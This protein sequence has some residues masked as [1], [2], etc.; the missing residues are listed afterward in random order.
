MGTFHNI[1]FS[2]L[3]EAPLGSVAGGIGVSLGAAAA[4]LARLDDRLAA[5]PEPIRRGWLNRMVLE[6]AAASAR[7][8]EIVVD[9]DELRLHAV[10]ALDADVDRAAGGA[11]RVELA[12]D[13]LRVLRSVTVRHHR[14]LFTPRRLT[15][16]ARLRLKG[17]PKEV[18]ADARIPAWLVEVPDPR[19]AREALPEALNTK[20]MSAWRT[21][22]PL[23]AGADLLALW[24]STGCAAA[25][26]GHVGR[27]LVPQL[28]VRLNA[29]A[30]PVLFPSIGYLGR[31][32]EYRPD[33][34]MNE[35]WAA[36]A[37]L[38][39][40]RRSAERGLGLHGKIEQAH[41]RLHAVLKPERSTGRGALVADHLIEVP[42]ATGRSVAKATGLSEVAARAMLERANEVGAVGELTGR[43]A[44]RVYGAA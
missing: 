17:R 22:P 11:D 28:L 29:T 7:L 42:A 44:F 9:A 41:A 36:K 20:N 26:G 8:E 31:A 27:S 6:E 39:A 37:W 5:S 40:C 2:P 30:A 18:R 33:L 24:S 16:A 15:A 4:A 25:V 23:L 32:W 14:H 1:G 38:D 12:T 21:L 3:R 10:G 43:A 34:V 13:I 35:E 19:K